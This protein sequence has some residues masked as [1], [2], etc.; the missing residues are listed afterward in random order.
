MDVGSCNR[1]ARSILLQL[2]FARIT[3]FNSVHISSEI[4][5]DLILGISVGVSLGLSQGLI[6][7]YNKYS[8][9]Y[10][11]L[12]CFVG[13]VSGVELGRLAI[14]ALE[15]V[16]LD[17]RIPFSGHALIEVLALALAGGIA[18]IALGSAQ[19]RIMR[20]KMPLIHRWRLINAMGW[21]L[22][23]MLS[24][25]LGII[26]NQ[27]PGWLFVRFERPE[28]TANLLAAISTGLVGGAITGYPLM[29]ALRRSAIQNPG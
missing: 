20:R 11:T 15:V 26:L 29:R 16:F 13:C 25:I 27:N 6:L 5:A 9:Y 1:L 3:A 2:L 14:A 17:L 18:G 7:S 28:L 23:C 24:A 22:G 10:W 21:M 12:A 4:Y 19:L 8:M